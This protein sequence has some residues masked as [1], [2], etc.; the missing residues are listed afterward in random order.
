M[1]VSANRLL[2]VEEWESLLTSTFNIVYTPGTV[3]QLS[4]FVWSLLKWTPASFRLVSNGCL[5][6]EKSYLRRL[7]RK[8][9]R[10]E[11]WAIPTKALLSHG[12]TLNYLH[13]LTREDRFCFMD[14]DIFAIGNFIPEITSQKADCAGIFGAMPIWVK[15]DGE[16]FPLSFRCMAGTFNRTEHGIPLGTTFLAV[17][18]NSLLTE[19]MQSTGIG[20]EDYTRDEIPPKI[21]KEMAALGLAV[22]IFD[23]GKV[24]NLCLS[25]NGGKL[26]NLEPSSLCHVGDTSFQVLSNRRP[27]SS[28]GK[29]VQKLRGTCL[30][31]TVARWQASRSTEAYRKR[32]ANAPEAEFRLNVAQRMS[33]RNPVRRYFLQLLHALFQGAP[34]PPPLVTGDEETDS[35]AGKVRAYLLSAFDEHRHRLEG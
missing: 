29:I 18:D 14:S 10:L 32:F 12:H 11:F 6:K 30:R 3:Q 22:D 24:L 27:K 7:C 23:T 17:Y 26:I 8:D 16:V 35:K 13:A 15:A 33:R 19:T 20:F 2:V 21:Q 25:T 5:P 4:F 34:V 9:P 28:K 31:N 1:W